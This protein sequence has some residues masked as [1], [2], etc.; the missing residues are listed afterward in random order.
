MRRI[1]FGIIGLGAIAEVHAKALENM[2]DACLFCGFDPVPGRAK[3]FAREHGCKGYDNLESF[4][5]DPD[6]EVVTVA[7][8]S[9][10]HEEIGRASCRERV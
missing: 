4:L 1:G 6:L 8:P 5:G 2:E 10:M 7:T 3:A 9:G